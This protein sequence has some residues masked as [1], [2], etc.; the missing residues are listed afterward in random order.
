M[1]PISR[2]RHSGQIKRL[3]VDLAVD[4]I[5]EEL[6]ELRGTDVGRSQLSLVQILARPRQV[7]VIG[8]DA[9]LAIPQQGAQENRV[10]GKHP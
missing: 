10:G 5:T 8:N 4:G 9:D 1:D 3:S 6:A 2:D 7:V